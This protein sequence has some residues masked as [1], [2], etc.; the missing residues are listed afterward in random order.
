[1]F[2][3]SEM[4]GTSLRFEKS[5]SLNNFQQKILNFVVM[6]R[7]VGNRVCV[8]WDTVVTVLGLYEFL[9]DSCTRGKTASEGER[10]G[11][12]W[13]HQHC[14]LGHASRENPGGW[15]SCG[16][17]DR[18]LHR[19]SGKSRLLIWRSIYGFRIPVFMA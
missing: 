14:Q 8:W 7:C 10:R 4:H 13:E 16:A 9:F 3:F 5:S 19:C 1:M 17:Q 2:Q 15:I 11:G 12:G 6:Y 18:H